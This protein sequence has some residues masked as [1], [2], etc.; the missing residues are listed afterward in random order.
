MSNLSIESKSKKLNHADSH[1]IKH[2]NAQHIIEMDSQNNE[3]QLKS[4][5]LG[6]GTTDKRLLTFCASFSISLL[7]LVFS[8]VRLSK[9][10]IKCN[11]QNQYVSL[12]SLVVGVWIRSPLS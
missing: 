2:E 10:G 3:N 6:G 7:I 11:E 4:C 5:C 8:C 9:S 1:I 12:I